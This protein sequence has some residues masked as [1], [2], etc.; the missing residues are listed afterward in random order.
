MIYILKFDVLLLGDV[1]EKFI[2][3]SLK[4]YGLCPSYLSAPGLNWDAMLKMTKVKL[5]LVSD[6]GM[7]IFFEEGTRGGISHISNIF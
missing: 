6:P 3:K 5:E 1:F 4:N 2:N 7:Y